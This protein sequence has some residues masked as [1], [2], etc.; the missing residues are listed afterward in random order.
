[1]KRRTRS[2]YLILSIALLCVPAMA[3]EPTPLAEEGA[4]TGLTIAGATLGVLGGTATALGFSAQAVDTP[5]SSALLVTIPVAAT[6]A[7]T[8]ALA[9]WWIA[10]ATLTLRPSL[11]LAPILG[12]GLGALGGAFVGALTFP[13]MAAIAIPTLTVPEGFWGD[14]ETLEAIGMAVL[15]GGVWGGIAGIAIGAVSVTILSAIMGF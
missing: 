12:A 8:G 7:A 3:E 5:L 14:F 11:L 9:G 2:L 4:R 6:G 1:M 13:V 10:E 15:S